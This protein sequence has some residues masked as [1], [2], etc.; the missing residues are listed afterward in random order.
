MEDARSVG[1]MALAETGQ[2]RDAIARQRDAI[3]LFQRTG[4]GAN[5]GLEEGL[6]RY[7]RGQPSRVPWSVDPLT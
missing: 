6:R 1:A 4:R 2:W 7:E 5:P 3:D